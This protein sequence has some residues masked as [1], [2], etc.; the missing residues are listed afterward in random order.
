MIGH[1]STAFRG[2]HLEPILFTG[3]RMKTQKVSFL[4]VFIFFTVGNGVVRYT[5][6][7]WLFFAC[8]GKKGREDWHGWMDGLAGKK[9]IAVMVIV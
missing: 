4:G 9:D 8:I 7:A 2:I 3:L 1:H 6:F 5:R